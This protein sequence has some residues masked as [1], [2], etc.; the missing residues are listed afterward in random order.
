MSKVRD[1]TGER[2]GN[3]TVVRMSKRRLSNN[4]QW[5]CQCI[6]GRFVIV[7]GD[8]LTSGRTGFC[9]VCSPNGR[10]SVFIGGDEIERTV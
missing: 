2:F 5:I 1:L 6:C 8:N 4:V 3:L 9:S 10:P 7:R